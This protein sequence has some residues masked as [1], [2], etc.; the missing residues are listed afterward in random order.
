MLLL[1]S[2]STSTTSKVRNLLM[3]LNFWTGISEP[4]WTSEWSVW[5]SETELLN[6]WTSELLL[7]LLNASFV[8]E[9]GF[10]N[11][12]ISELLNFWICDVAV[13]MLHTA[14]W[15]PDPTVEGDFGTQRENLY[16]L[17]G[18]QG[19]LTRWAQIRTQN[20]R[21]TECCALP[22]VSS[23]ARRP[24]VA[25]VCLASDSGYLIPC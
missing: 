24:L 21:L 22:A 15:R 25:C 18:F 4:V 13:V 6:L 20:K 23:S 14:T 7:E 8:L 2:I 16:K 5:I 10:L 12:W 3:V 11:F 9:P 19:I 1:I 17:N